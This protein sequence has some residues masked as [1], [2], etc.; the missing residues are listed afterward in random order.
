MALKSRIHYSFYGE[1][2]ELQIPFQPHSSHATIH[3]PFL[4]KNDF[5]F[6][7]ITSEKFCAS[8]TKCGEELVGKYGEC[9]MHP[10]EKRKI[11]EKSTN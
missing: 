11:N 10:S 4:P 7:E 9:Q 1:Q 8:E 6:R 3:T 2:L 5:I